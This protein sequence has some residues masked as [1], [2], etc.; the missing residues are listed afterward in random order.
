[1]DVPFYK[2][3]LDF[4]C[5]PACLLMALKAQD[6]ATPHSF[7]L[8]VD[9]WREATIG[10]VPATMPH[11]LALAAW[12]RGFSTRLVVS[13][14]NPPFEARIRA[15]MY[16]GPWQDALGRIWDDLRARTLAAGIREEVR[17][18]A[19]AD[20]DRALDAGE[21]PI[22]LTDT[23]HF[24]EDEKDI[25]H[26]VVV[27]ERSHRGY[28]VHDPLHDT[29]ARATLNAKDLEAALGYQGDQALVAVGPR[30]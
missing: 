10:A 7:E 23:G 14:T 5:G 20:V 21:V 22:I 1:V 6:A 8:E 13:S 26:W 17:P 4:S 30:R 16:V 18:V 25:P 28:V 12:R 15:R 24:S 2:Q 19:L 9:L 11:G 3:T 29:A 27:G